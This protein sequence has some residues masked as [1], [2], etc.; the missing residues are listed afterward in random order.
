MTSMNPAVTSGS[1]APFM[2]L[3]KPTISYRLRVAV[4]ALLGRKSGI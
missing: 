3:Y 1:S 4:R 2:P